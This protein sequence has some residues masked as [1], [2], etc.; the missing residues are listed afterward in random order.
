MNLVEALKTGK[1]LRRPIVKHM[2]SGGTGYLDS[3]Y[4]MGLLICGQ[5]RTS[6]LGD[7]FVSRPL[8]ISDVDI[9]ADDWEIK[10]E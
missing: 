8:M 1:P 7:F 6:Y 10:N 5:I 4:A 9:L 3:E 2:G